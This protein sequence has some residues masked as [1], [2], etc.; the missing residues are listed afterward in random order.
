M[1]KS[2]SRIIPVFI[3]FWIFVYNPGISPSAENADQRNTPDKKNETAV[4][5]A[6]YLENVLFE[7]LPG[8]ERIHLVVSQP[9]SYTHLTLPTIY[10]V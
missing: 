6:G 7:K 8:K 4:A 10:S 9:V 3:V 1:K 5:K 2:L